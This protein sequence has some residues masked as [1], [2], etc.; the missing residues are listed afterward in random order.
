[1]EAKFEVYKDESE[2]F[3]WKLVHDSGQVIANS[4]ESY[5][6]K[7][8]AMESISS[9]VNVIVPDGEAKQLSRAKAPLGGLSFNS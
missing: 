6:T 4:G 7:V 9:L 5:P 3:R 2:D 1:M 8:L